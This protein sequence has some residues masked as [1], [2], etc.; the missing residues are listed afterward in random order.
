MELIRKEDFRY[1][2]ELLPKLNNLQASLSDWPGL[3]DYVCIFVLTSFLEKDLMQLNC[4]E[5]ILWA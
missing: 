1:L 3:I 2:T 5:Y 4:Q